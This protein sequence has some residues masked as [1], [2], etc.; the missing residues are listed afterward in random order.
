MNWTKKRTLSNAARARSPLFEW[1]RSLPLR[2]PIWAAAFI[3][4]WL[5]ADA[6]PILFFNPRAF[7]QQLEKYIDA[8]GLAIS[9][10]GVDVSL[11]RGIRIIGLRV[12]FDRDFSR[13][14]YLLEAPSVYLHVPLGWV[15]PNAANFL[16]ETRIVVEG[17]KLAYWITAD[18]ADSQVIAQARKL[19]Q[20]NLAYHVE[21]NGC[22]FALNVKD[23][24]YFK[25]VTPIQNLYF[26]IKHLGKEVQ[27]M[28]RYE[29][30]TIGSG[31]FFGKFKPCETLACE[32]LQG[33]WYFK[34]VKLNTR[35]LNNFQKDL[36]I[37]SG[38]VSGE[39]AFD[40][41]LVDVE[42]QLRGKSTTMREPQS[43]FRL[44]VNAHDFSISKKKKEWYRADTFGVSTTITM[45]GTSA[46]GSAKASLENYEID[47]EFQ[48]LRPDALPEKYIFRVKPNRFGKR[49][50]YLPGGKR[51][52]GLNDLTFHLAERVGNRYKK[53]E[54]NFQV[55]D[56]LFSLGD[57]TTIPPLQIPLAELSLNNDK[58]T[59][60]LQL[61]RG[62]SSLAAKADGVVSLYPVNFKPRTNSY[63]RESSATREHLIFALQG[64]VNAPIVCENIEWSEALPYVNFWL[65]DYWEEVKDGMQYSWLPSHLKRREWF[66]R[67]VQYLDFSMP[68][69]VK[70]FSWGPATPLRGNF[71]FAPQYSGGGFRLESPD[72]RIATQL[73]V[74]YASDEPNSPYLTHEL[75]LKVDH[76][77]ELLKPWFG[78]DYF[79]Y[80][81]GAEIVHNNNF[82]GE[83]AAD[84][85]LKT[86]SVTDMRLSRVRLGNWARAQLLP[87]QWETIDVRANRG[88][89]FGAVTS[90]KAENDNTILTGYGEYKLF[91]RQLETQLKHTEIIK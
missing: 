37:A 39:V 24:S 46:T 58:L 60:N 9:Y 82:N 18:S 84:H 50:L 71:Y 31:D 65:D 83:R 17:G 63:I 41:R 87:L 56:G 54:L 45:Q 88:N 11:F 15:H 36:H 91:D 80:F 43:I 81:Y 12:S 38:T 4:L 10:Q 47:A 67:F 78:G 49:L 73:S 1:V 77:Y 74:S 13:G 85:Y 35:I 66:V 68:I 30:S 76:A 32:D 3:A 27:T 61:R 21:C 40:R 62:T 26:T 53:A 6:L 89:G 72:G 2:Y 70:N 51:L 14:R 69:E 44:A 48:D 59:G 75:R 5:I 64:R 25:E 52:T 55:A 16:A 22:E 90:I 34:P 79:E 8:S 86:M 23:N 7:Q 42:R 28:V 19:L 29:S 20:E 33:Y 57:D